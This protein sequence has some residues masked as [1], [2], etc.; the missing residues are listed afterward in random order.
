MIMHIIKKK[1]LNKVMQNNKFL[2]DIQHADL[3]LGIQDNYKNCYGTWLD[4]NTLKYKES[5]DPEVI[6][7]LQIDNEKITIQ[8][9]GE[10]SSTIICSL[11]SRTKAKIETDFGAFDFDVV[12]E[13][14]EISSKLLRV[15]YSLYQQDA[16]VS[17]FHVCWTIKEV[18]A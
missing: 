16:I 13:E 7:I 15:Q 8:R 1:R 3:L 11:E 18:Q 14:V 2:I 10:M 9:Q 12:T 5:C 6:V 4:K 17:R